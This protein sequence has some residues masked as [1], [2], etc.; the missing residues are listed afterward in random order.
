MKYLDVKEKGIKLLHL[1]E[2]L[3]LKNKEKMKKVIHKFLD[4]KN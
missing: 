2:D 1:R 4:F 3:W